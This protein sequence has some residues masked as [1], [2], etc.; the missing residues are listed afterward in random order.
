MDGQRDDI[1]RWEGDVP[2]SGDVDQ[3]RT[4]VL[5]GVGRPPDEE[6]GVDVTAIDDANEIAEVIAEE[7]DEEWG[8]RD[9][10][11]VVLVDADEDEVDDFV[12][13]NESVYGYAPY[14]VE[15]ESAA[16][17]PARMEGVLRGD[18]V[19]RR[20]FGASRPS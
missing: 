20:P 4:W 13:D 8:E 14:L 7:H 11:W 17:T 19:K 1:R 9:D 10:G 2:A 15:P 3:F 18:R 5:W 16:A 6:Y 12:M